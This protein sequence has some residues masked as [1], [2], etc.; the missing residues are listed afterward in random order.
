ML[1]TML[2][3]YLRVSDCVSVALAQ[4]SLSKLGW[5]EQ[6]DLGFDSSMKKKSNRITFILNPSGMENKQ[7]LKSL[8]FI[9]NI[10]HFFF[11]CFFF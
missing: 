6:G 5:T 4:V 7:R 1:C 2:L 11:V 8:L 10:K 3:S 9:A